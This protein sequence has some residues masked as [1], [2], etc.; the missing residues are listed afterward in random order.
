MNIL[1][2]NGNLTADAK[3]LK[4]KSDRKFF[5]FTLANNKIHY[6]KDKTQIK[7]TT[8]IDC[9]ASR[10]GL[11]NYVEKYGKKGQFATICGSIQI[12]E[13]EKDGTKYKNVHVIIDDLH[14][15]VN[16]VTIGDKPDMTV[17]VDD[18]PF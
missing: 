9:I 11:L 17:A 15:S 13:T 1:V 6:N 10:D 7:T 5:T 8:F 3:A 2:I 12:K 4:S 14:F 18:I 16:G